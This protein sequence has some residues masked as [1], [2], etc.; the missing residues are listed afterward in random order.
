[1]TIDEKTLLTKNSI[2]E[3]VN[4]TF[5][6]SSSFALALY[7]STQTKLY[8]NNFTKI[9]IKLISLIFL[10][11]NILYAFFNVYDYYIFINKNKKYIPS[12]Y[13]NIFTN[14]NIAIFYFYLIL[15]TFILLFNLFCVF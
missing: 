4:R 13:I 1:M 5:F 9:T 10:F 7:V 15:L 8:K 14:Y 11:L 6:T 2:F 3:S 12:S